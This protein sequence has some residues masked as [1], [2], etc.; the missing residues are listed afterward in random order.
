MDGWM[1]GFQQILSLY[2]TIQNFMMMDG[3]DEVESYELV[4][5]FG[6][7]Y[8][9]MAP[10]CRAWVDVLFE[11]HSTLRQIVAVTLQRF[12]S[13]LNTSCFSPN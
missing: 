4:H 9:F 5:Y 7:G 6:R 13:G 3:G 8:T 1:D 10:T 2:Y 12:L 11:Q